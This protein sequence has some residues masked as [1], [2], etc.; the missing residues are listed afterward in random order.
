[1]R[2]FWALPLWIVCAVPAAAQDIVVTAD[3][4]RLARNEA[5][6][7]SVASLQRDALAQIG[8]QVPSEA[9]NRLPGVS[10][11]RNNGV[12]NLIAIRSPVLTGGQSAGSFLVMDNGVPIRAP[13]FS[14]VNQIWE[15]SF[16]FADR[17][18]VVRGPGSSLY[19]SN[20]VHGLVNVV[21]QSGVPD[22]TRCLR[23]QATA[24]ADSQG[25]TQ[26]SLLVRRGVRQ[27]HY[28]RCPWPEP[29]VTD[30]D[31]AIPM[32][33]GTTWR[34][35]A[36]LALEH[37]AGWRAQ[38]GLDRQSAIFSFG[39]GSHYEPWELEGRLVAQ[40]LN[41]ESAGFI[42]GPRAYDNR[43]FAETNPV[44]EAY[45]DTRLIRAQATLTRYG[46]DFEWRITPFARFIETDLN[47]FFFPSRAQEVTRQTGA[48]VQASVAW[49]ARSNVAVIAGFDLDVS[50]GGLREFQAR[51]TVG[52]FTQGLHYDYEVDMLAAGAYAHAE[53]VFAPDWTLTAGLRAER[54]AYDYDTR[55][56]AGDVGRFRRP[57]DREDE[58]DGLAPRLSLSW[59]GDETMAWASFARGQRPPQIT[60]L[61][62]LQ[63]RQN[64]GEQ[65][66]ETMDAVELGWRGRTEVASLELVAF[67][68]NK[69]DTSFRGADGLTVTGGQTRHV[70]VE[71]AGEVALSPQWS[72][73]GWA[74]F[75]EHS[76]RFDSPADGIRNGNLID[77]APRWLA[78]AR[79][80][81]SPREK[82]G[83]E[84]EWTHVGESFT[85]AANA[86]VYGGHDLV[87]LRAFAP[88]SDDVEA[89]FAVRNLTNTGYADRAD[90][91]FGVD[92][93]FP[94]APRSVTVGLRYRR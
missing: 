42:E 22:D 36:G 70:G 52:T 12:E 55:T 18:T 40:N 29:V 17:V 9:L 93:Y 41:Q 14:N 25:R 34:A 13:G 61:Y 8:A 43:S 87:N 37:D 26:A 27:S 76:Y 79:V 63:T 16:D 59:E 69:R 68:M 45:R 75:A 53:W 15:T 35:T 10:I 67:A 19:G 90:F 57:A 30:S 82:V 56:L 23:E 4:D 20:A 32:S 7:A 28:T 31:I 89:F 64:S 80:T 2:Y 81:Y 38:S 74:S 85:D 39:R 47:L 72:L 66:V 86:R 24:A 65:G 33:W 60:D 11:Q 91:A 92:R 48:G 78:N 94:G 46:G 1:M 73:A 84:L 5:A 50:R 58:F 83:V 51:P 44:P 3:R 54:V 21:T 62:A 88:V 6:P 77:T 49:E 71:A